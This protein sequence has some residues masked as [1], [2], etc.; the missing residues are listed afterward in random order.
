MTLSREEADKLA[1][2]I[3]DCVPALI[4][5]DFAEPLMNLCDY[6][7]SSGCPQ[8]NAPGN[9]EAQAASDPTQPSNGEPDF[10]LLHAA[11][12]ARFSRYIARDKAKEEANE[13]V[14]FL[15]PY[16]SHQR[17]APSVEDA[18]VKAALTH[19]RR[20]NA[21]VD[22]YHRH[23]YADL[24][25]RL[26]AYTAEL[27]ARAVRSDTVHAWDNGDDCAPDVTGERVERWCIEA[28]AHHASRQRAW[29]GEGK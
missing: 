6:I 15:Q 24:L 3:K 12:I 14:S 16:L 22:Q 10:S 18:L 2:T 21:F 5:P 11:L 17:P 27:E 1:R 13:I 20:P 26:A 19:L 29:K 25:E 7:L 9:Y 4:K 28:L 8:T 23:H